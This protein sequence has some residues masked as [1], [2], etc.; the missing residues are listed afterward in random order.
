MT[1]PT[2]METVHSVDKFL[3]PWG[4]EIDLKVI[5]YDSGLGMV[6]MTIREKHRF[7]MV[8]LDRDSALKL[9]RHLL[10]WAETA[11]PEK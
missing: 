11:A 8:D 9:A 3:V 10:A 5:D 2:G 6:R 1:G 7:T 4:K